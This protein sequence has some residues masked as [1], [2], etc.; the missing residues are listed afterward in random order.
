M[1]EKQ[2]RGYVTLP[3][4]ISVTKLFRVTEMCFHLS[5]M[6]HFLK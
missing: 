2:L 5:K 4:N 3:A 1:N 6:F